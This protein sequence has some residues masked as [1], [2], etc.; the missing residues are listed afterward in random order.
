V[1]VCTVEPGAPAQGSPSAQLGAGG[2]VVAVPPPVLVAA[3]PQEL[4]ELTVVQ[5]GAP[6]AK[7]HEP[8]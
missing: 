5:T 6:G 2:Q 7:Q 4:R 3:P 1:Q 8:V